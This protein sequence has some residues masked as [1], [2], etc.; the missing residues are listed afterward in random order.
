M[1]ITIFFLFGCIS[2]ADAQSPGVRNGHA[3]VYNRDMHAMILFGGA[4]EK[5][6][7]EDTWG[8]VRGNWKKLSENGPGF[9]TFPAMVMADHYILLFGGNQVLFGDEQHPAHYLDDTWIYRKG[10]WKKLNLSVHPSP[11]AEMAIG[12]DPVR[13]IILLFG[14]RQSGDQWILGDSWEFDGHQWIPVNKPGPCARSGAVMTYDPDLKQLVLFGGNPVIAKEP[15]Y[16]GP[17]WSWDGG[18]WHQMPVNDSLVFN[19]CM[20]Y[21]AADHFLLRY[22][23]WNGRERLSDSWKFHDGAWEKLNPLPFPEARNHAIM[24]YDNDTGASILFG[25]HD[26]DYVFGDLWSF[27]SGKWSLLHAEKPRKRIDNGH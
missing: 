25:G 15:T 23:G 10:Q 13:R 6:V 20:V 24:A 2:I 7:C 27:K 1:K 21:D 16:N 19:S 26:G 11:R 18:S 4:D 9:R 5:K 17:M 8:Y 14:G 22:G 12:Y 3:M